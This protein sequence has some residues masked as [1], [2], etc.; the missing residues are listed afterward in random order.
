M[1]GLGWHNYPHNWWSSAVK[2]FIKG[3]QLFDIFP[4]CDIDAWVI[5]GKQFASEHAGPTN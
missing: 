5:E 2:R 4:F 1:W 3:L